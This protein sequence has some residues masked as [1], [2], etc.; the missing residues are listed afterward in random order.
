MQG[1]SGRSHSLLLQ[2]LN[3]AAEGSLRSSS[4]LGLFVVPPYQNLAGFSAVG[5]PDDAFLFHHLNNSGSP[6][7]TDTQG[8]LLHVQ[9]HA[10]NTHDTVAGCHVFEEAIKQ[11]PTLQGVCADAG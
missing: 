7:V 5:R 6:I 11:Y 4:G 8:H 10:A 1:I 9:V 2:A 3:N